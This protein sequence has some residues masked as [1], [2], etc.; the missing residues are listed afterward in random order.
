M[1]NSYVQFILI[2]TKQIVFLKERWGNDENKTFH[3]IKYID[4]YSTIIPIAQQ[5]YVGLYCSDCACQTEQD[6]IIQL[7]NTTKLLKNL[8]HV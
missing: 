6:E 2:R 8:Y 5:L 7:K 1:V 3:W 4:F